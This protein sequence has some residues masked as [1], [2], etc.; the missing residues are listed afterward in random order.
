MF[1]YQIFSSS[2]W[3]ISIVSSNFPA[4]STVCLLPRVFGFLWGWHWGGCK[5]GARRRVTP[6][7]NKSWTLRYAAEAWIGFLAEEMYRGGKQLI[8]THC[9]KHGRE[10]VEETGE[11]EANYTPCGEAGALPGFLQGGLSGYDSL[12]S[13][14]GMLRGWGEMKDMTNTAETGIEILNYGPVTASDR[15][16]YAT[17]MK[18]WL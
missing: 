7:Q 12:M 5:S 13:K 17:M 6:S 9:H 10:G 3:T 14:D 15:V 8:Y 16:S 2:I 18:E 11:D 1:L 4:T